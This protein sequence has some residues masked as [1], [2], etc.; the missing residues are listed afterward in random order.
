MLNALP[1]IVVEADAIVTYKKLL[2]RHT[3]M[4][5]IEGY[6]SCGGRGD[7]AQ[8]LNLERSCFCWND[9]HSSS[10]LLPLVIY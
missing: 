7:L 3:N 5:R 1:G 6:G 9:I 4:L 8:T 10:I 2:N